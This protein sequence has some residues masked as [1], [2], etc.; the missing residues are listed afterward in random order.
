MAKTFWCNDFS[1]GNLVSPLI[2]SSFRQKLFFL[3]IQ[4]WKHALLDKKR[5]KWVSMTAYNTSIGIFMH[6]FVVD[7]AWQYYWKLKCPEYSNKQFILPPSFQVIQQHRSGRATQPLVWPTAWLTFWVGQEEWG[8]ATSS[9]PTWVPRRLADGRGMAL[10]EH[11]S[12][13]KVR[14]PVIIWCQ[15][16]WYI[17]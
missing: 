15:N 9:P 4:D 7:K 5:R 1:L 14:R 11:K 17:H 8:T 10:C 2:K 12:R 13:C 6:W 3:F 16:S